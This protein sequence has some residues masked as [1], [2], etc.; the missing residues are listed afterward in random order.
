MTAS[1]MF[2]ALADE[3]HA[4]GQRPPSHRQISPR[5]Q[6]HQRVVPSSRPSQ[7]LQARDQACRNGLRPETLD[8]FPMGMTLS[9]LKKPTSAPN[10]AR[11]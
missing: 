5:L 6:G 11:S 3:A 9:G 2:I 10:R 1:Q 8:L 4:E 7:V